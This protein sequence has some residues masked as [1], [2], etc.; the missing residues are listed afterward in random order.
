MEGLYFVN[1]KDLRIK[2]FKEV[3]N[4]MTLL[5]RFV[6]YFVVICGGIMLMYALMYGMYK[7]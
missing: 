5:S 6:G 7:L 4:V 2:L 1:W 3:G